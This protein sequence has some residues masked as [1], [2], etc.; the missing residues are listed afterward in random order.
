MDS[1]NLILNNN[2][3]MKHFSKGFLNLETEDGVNNSGEKKT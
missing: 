3:K 2:T 1:K